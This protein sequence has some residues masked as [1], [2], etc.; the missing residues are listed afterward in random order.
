MM[1]KA[2]ILLIRLYRSSLGLVLGGQCRFHP[3][4]SAYCMEAVEKHGA[5][6]GTWLGAK[7]LLRCH[8]FHPGGVDPVPGRPAGSRPGAK[9]IFS[10]H[11]SLECR[12]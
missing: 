9:T 6:R 2:I 7:R 5:M 1:A 10:G 3:S 12:L 4:C 8:P 11:H